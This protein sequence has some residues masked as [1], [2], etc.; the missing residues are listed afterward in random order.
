MKR[1]R[2]A[3]LSVVALML[4]TFPQQ[5]VAEDTPKQPTRFTEDLALDTRADPG[6]LEA[7]IRQLNEPMDQEQ[8]SELILA[9]ASLEDPNEME[10]LQR[11]LDERIARL[12]KPPTER[13]ATPAGEQGAAS[14]EAVEQ[15]VEVD[16]LR[17]E[18]ATLRLGPDATVDDLRKRDEV[19]VTIAGI[20]DPDVRYELLQLLE[21]RERSADT[22]ATETVNR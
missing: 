7:A 10:R 18:I 15:A 3:G 5:S 17:L 2:V 22:V 1:L 16:L 21:D 9:L 8:F 11:L 14:Q 19:V 20:S 4:G 12:S 6:E 13:T